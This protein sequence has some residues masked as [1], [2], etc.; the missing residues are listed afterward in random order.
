M[1]A[2]ASPFY[3]TG[4]TLIPDSPSAALVYAPHGRDGQ[5]AAALLKEAGVVSKVVSSFQSFVASLGEE[6]LF[7]VVTEETLRTQDMR[8]I[9]EWV[10]S[11]PSWSDLPFIV[12]AHRGAGPERNPAASRLVELLGNVSFLE[13]PFHPTTFISV[14]NTASKGR[15]R[16]YEARNRV[17]QLNESELRLKTA[18]LA[19]RLGTWELR[20]ADHTLAASDVC[21]NVF[22]CK[23][24]EQFSYADLIEA[25]HPD[26]RER[27]QRS[28][29]ET[30]Q[31][32]SDYLIEFRVVWPDKS[33]HWAELR[34]RIVRD[35]VG[36]PA[37]LVG[38]A[39]DISERKAA[40][41]ALRSVNEILEQRVEERTQELRKAHEQLVAEAVQ[42]E[43]AE[44]RLRQSQKLEAL[45]QLTGGVAHDFNNLLMAVLGNLELIRK[46]VAEDARTV[47][48]VDGALQGARRGASLTQRLLAF[49]RQQDL[50]VKPTNLADLVEG[51]RELLVR[52]V[53]GAIEIASDFEEDL[54]LVLADGN[55]M[56]LA[57]LNLAVNARDAMQNGGTITIG[58]RKHLH[59]RPSS[60]LPRRDY[61]C[62]SVTDT[63][64]GMDAATLQRAV[65]PFFSTKELGKGTGLGLSMIHGLALQLGGALKL[66]ST[67]GKGTTAQIWLPATDL[68]NQEDEKGEIQ[69][70]QAPESL[71]IL[72]VDDDALIAMSTVDMLEDL[73]HRV[74]D[75]SS[76]NDALAIVSAA[77]DI[78]LIITDYSM[79][80]MNGAQLAKAVRE[81]RPD[82]PVLVATGYADLPPGTGMNLPR[83]SKPYTQ[84]QLEREIAIIFSSRHA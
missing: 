68:A 70:V 79:P 62:L 14:V 77:E 20:L 5:V 45:G 60:D 58:L 33:E 54:P 2:A 83:L 41:A 26:D 42:R 24:E 36:L 69:M 64:E 74:V 63:G 71:K 59:V 13:R 9:H 52:S 39:S 25:I 84:E 10:R 1:S 82:L 37:R 50:Q 15:R 28:I 11:Q 51:M 44:E 27:M 3:W 19:G 56:E 76:G 35:R 72:V 4:A 22:G 81:I 34:G 12:L 29:T 65:D 31:T 67:L 23:P 46:N 49:A 66:E 6:C 7:I 17:E 38:V 57:L 48:L 21:K 78:D 43:A 73:G 47:R 61:V 32:G 40:E 53:G 16:Q 8:P 80:G 18:L 55:Q 75:A 30:L